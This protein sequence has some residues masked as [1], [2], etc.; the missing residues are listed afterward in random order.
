MRS[1]LF[2]E[3]RL[4]RNEPVVA[5]AL[6]ELA[7]ETGYEAAAGDTG[8]GRFAPQPYASMPGFP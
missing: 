7:E 5:D 3:G 1:L 6:R 4:R 8:S 2:A